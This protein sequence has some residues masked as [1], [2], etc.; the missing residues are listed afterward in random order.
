MGNKNRSR[1]RAAITAFNRSQESARIERVNRQQRWEVIRTY[2]QAYPTRWRELVNERQPQWN[3]STA[4]KRVLRQSN[5]ALAREA[6]NTANTRNR[7][8]AIRVR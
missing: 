6:E 7:D 1:N 2:V 5:K 8:A 3:V 4:P